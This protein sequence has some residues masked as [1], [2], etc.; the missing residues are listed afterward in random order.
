MQEQEAM[1]DQERER[2]YSSFTFSSVTRQAQLRSNTEDFKSTIRHITDIDTLP[3]FVYVLRRLRRL[4][5]V[6]PITDISMFKKGIEPMWEDPH[7]IGGGKWIIK[8]KKGVVEQR[9]FERLLLRT[10]LGPMETMDVNGVVVSVRSNQTILSI[11]TRFGPPLGEEESIE[12][13]I[14]EVLDVSDRIPLAFKGNDESLKD[15]SS[16]R[17]VYQRV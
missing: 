3:E 9:L 5:T 12:R 10:V 2:L 13:E 11:W 16:F 15:K 14:R 7:N 4:S 1:E 8:V 6:R 17:N